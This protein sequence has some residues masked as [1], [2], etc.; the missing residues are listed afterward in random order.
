MSYTVRYHVSATVIRQD[1]ETDNENIHMA[2]T[3]E[4]THAAHDALTHFGSMIDILARGIVPTA[5][6]AAIPAGDA[7]A[8]EALLL[9]E[10]AR[11]GRGRPAGSAAGGKPNPVKAPETPAVTATTISEAGTATT[12]IHDDAGMAALLAG[13]APRESV[14]DNVGMAALLAG[15]ITKELAAEDADLN[16]LLAGGSG[17]MADGDLAAL[18]GEDTSTVVVP[19]EQAEARYVGWTH[20]QAY[21]DMKDNRIARHGMPWLRTFLGGIRERDKNS[22][23][24]LNDISTDE[25]IAE[26]VRLDGLDA[27]MTK[28]TA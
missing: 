17:S 7:R 1:A 8:A 18:L 19:G 2:L 22:N 4:D 11:R 12:D 26:L 6:R 24:G 25:L 16:A 23:M 21:A 10:T 5:A 9:T 14:A 27:E 15:E 13:D 20:E 28:V 3:T